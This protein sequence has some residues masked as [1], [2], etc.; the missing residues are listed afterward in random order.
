MLIIIVAYVRAHPYITYASRGRVN[1]GI[2]I[3]VEP[4]TFDKI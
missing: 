4:T 3:T 2:N 1:C